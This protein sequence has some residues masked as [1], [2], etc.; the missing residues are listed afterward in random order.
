LFAFKAG[1]AKAALVFS[2]PC[3]PLASIAQS[4]EY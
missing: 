1:P 3:F 4:L 2:L